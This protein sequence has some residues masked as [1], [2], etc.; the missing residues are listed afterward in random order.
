MIKIK[1]RQLNATRDGA[2]TSE[3]RGRFCDEKRPV[4][5]E[6]IAKL[7]SKRPVN[8]PLYA[9]VRFAKA[10][11]V[12]ITECGT[13]IAESRARKL[14]RRNLFRLF[15]RMDAPKMRVEAGKCG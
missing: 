14:G 2:R 11:G 6:D 9:F 1:T 12:S 15:P 10:G 8:T 13:G 4:N 7:R 5:T 3:R